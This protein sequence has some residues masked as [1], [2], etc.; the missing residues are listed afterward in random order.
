MLG[1]VFSW[2]GRNALGFL[3][4][5]SSDGSGSLAAALSSPILGAYLAAWA[6]FHLAEYLVTAIYNP[7]KAGVDCAS[8][9]LPL[10]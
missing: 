1:A 4:A 5:L 6:V 3:G 2:F 7:E 10:R 9:C 8:T